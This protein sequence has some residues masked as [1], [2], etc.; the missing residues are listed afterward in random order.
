MIESK[1]KF[2][3]NSF[4]NKRGNETL[5]HRAVKQACERLFND[6]GKGVT[7]IEQEKFVSGR[8]ADLYVHFSIGPD[9][10]VEV[11][12]SRMTVTEVKKRTSHYNSRNIH[13]LWLLNGNGPCVAS[14][15]APEDKRSAKISSLERFLHWMYGGRVYYV[16]LN[17]FR[18]GFKR[19]QVVSDPFALHFSLPEKKYLHG[20]FQDNFQYYCHRNVL[21]V[22]IPSWTLLRVEFN[23]FKLARFYDKNAKSFLKERIQELVRVKPH[24]KERKLVKSI[25]S[26]FNP[27]YGKRLVLTAT[28]ELVQ[29]NQLEMS[30]KKVRK[31]QK[32]L[33]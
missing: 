6:N 17:R 3:D 16:N 1:H 23:G 9:V 31:I 30:A 29:R 12:N 5:Y 18:K 20:L 27:K 21:V 22:P 15:K 24:H 33:V 13:V 2:H 14:P 10:V 28:M 4:N 25:Q 11:Q 19:H 8:R 32:Y 7:G 26:A